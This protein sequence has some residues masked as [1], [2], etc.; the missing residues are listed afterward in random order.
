MLECVALPRGCVDHDQQL[1]I[2]IGLTG[3][4]RSTFILGC[5]LCRR[6]VIFLS[7][8]THDISQKWLGC[9]SGL[10]TLDSSP[11]GKFHIRKADEC[12]GVLRHLVFFDILLSGCKDLTEG[13]LN[14]CRHRQPVGSNGRFIAA[15][16][17]QLAS[18]G[19]AMDH[20]FTIPF[21]WIDFENRELSVGSQLRG[22]HASPAVIGRMVKRTFLPHHRQ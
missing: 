19:I 6:D 17:G 2:I 14:E 18:V 9:Q 1:A 5:F 22:R 20:K 21:L 3:F 11:F 8:I 15:R 12:H 16:Y 7:C 4:L 10:I 13:R